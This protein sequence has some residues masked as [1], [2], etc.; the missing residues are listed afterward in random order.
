VEKTTTGK[1][2]GGTAAETKA[3]LG[4]RA[5][6][7]INDAGPVPQGT[8]V[9]ASVSD[10]EWVIPRTYGI[11]RI[12][13]CEKG[14]PFTVLEVGA[15]TDAIDLGDN[16]KLPFAIGA[17]DIAEDLVQELERHGVFVCASGVP[18]EEELHDARTKREAWLRELIQE[19]DMMWARGHTYRE[20]SDMHRRATMALGVEREW[21]YVPGQHMDCPVC[22]EKIKANVAVC[23]HCR[24]VLDAERAAKHGIAAHGVAVRMP[25]QTVGK[26]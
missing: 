23:K 18:T 5:V 17:R 26:S 1:Q 9:I 3:P 7:Y 19:A 24:A 11:F 21:A 14:Q 22:G 8:A 13:A 2:R 10:Q 6:R 16:R 20:I 15:R 4:S 12:P 25:A